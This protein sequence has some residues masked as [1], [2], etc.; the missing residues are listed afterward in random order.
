MTAVAVQQQDRKPEPDLSWITGARF[1]ALE[2]L[3]TGQF[4]EFPLKQ[5][6][7]KTFAYL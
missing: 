4:P 2:S 1:M 6:H 7:R 5:S 3:P